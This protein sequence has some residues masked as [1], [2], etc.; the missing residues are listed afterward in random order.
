[1]A[2]LEIETL[3]SGYGEAIV[4]EEMS[5][6]IAES[7][8]LAVL[9][10]N[11][12]GKTT[13]MLAI[14]GHIRQFGG[15]VRWSGRDISRLPANA[16]VHL[17]IGWVPQERDIFKSLTVEENLMVA[18]RVGRFD[19]AAIY[20]LFPRLR[21]R[22]RNMGDKL[23][24]GEQQML[25]IGRALM[26]NPK[27]LLLDEPF[28]GLA[29]IIVEELEDTIRRLRRDYGFA[30]VIVEQHAEDAL[31]LSDRAIVLDRGRIVLEGLAQDLLDDFDS[32][33]RWIAV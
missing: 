19:A 18:E 3:T 8:G 2:L 5:L 4:L 22:R 33:Q 20:D 9:G 14:M 30:T 26:T 28:E 1:M 29:P 16:R 31:R 25:A 17:G 23:S 13:L 11:G 10:R 32:V 7:E 6:A 27:L 24:G 12:V 15:T 21:E